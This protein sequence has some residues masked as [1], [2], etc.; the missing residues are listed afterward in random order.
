MLDASGTSGTI[1]WSYPEQTY[2]NNI[3][4]FIAGYLTSVSCNNE[5]SVCVAAGT[6]R[7]TQTDSA[8]ISTTTQYPLALITTDGGSTWNY[9][10]SVIPSASLNATAS[11]LTS[12]SASPS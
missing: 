1:T 7:A 5:G 4:G 2:L 3:D 12:V 6:Y 10:S 9:N 8:G 11:S